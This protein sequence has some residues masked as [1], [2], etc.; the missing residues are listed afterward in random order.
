MGVRAKSFLTQ[1]TRSDF[2]HQCTLYMFGVSSKAVQVLFM[3]NRSNL[4]HHYWWFT[5]GGLPQDDWTDFG[6]LQLV[7]YPVSGMLHD[8][9]ALFVASKRSSAKTLY[10]GAEVKSFFSGL[11]RL[12]LVSGFI[13]DNLSSDWSVLTDHSKATSKCSLWISFY[14]FSFS[15]FLECVRFPI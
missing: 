6:I 5:S 11:S 15:L 8:L 10:R 2:T 12:F 3:C 9:F 1:L 7:I 14:W 13:Q 4:L